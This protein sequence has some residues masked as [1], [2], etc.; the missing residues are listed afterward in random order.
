VILW[1]AAA[2]MAAGTVA[3]LV[4]PFVRPREDSGHNSELLVYQD[5]LAETDRDVERGLLT[6][7][8]A[9][10][11]RAEITRRMDK[12]PDTE[13]AGTGRTGTSGG[14]GID[15]IAISGVMVV[16][17]AGTLG[18]YLQLG[19]PGKRDLPFASRSVAPEGTNAASAAAQT[20]QG[21]EL[22]R[23]ANNL[24]QKMQERPD[25]LEGWMLLG[26][27]YMTLERWGDAA[28]AFGRAHTLSPRGPDI[29]ASY[30]EALYMAGGRRFDDQSK[31]V[32]QAALRANPR[33]AKS[34]FYW[35]LAQ[36]LSDQH[37]GALQT[38]VNLRVISPPNAP[39]LP[40]LSQR[41]QQSAEAGGINVAT[42]K[43]TL[44]PRQF[45]RP[46]PPVASAQPAP[47][48]R[49]ERGPT[50]EDVRAAQEMS[51]EDRMAFIRSMVEGLASRLEDNPND[52]AGWRRLAR[53]YRVLGETEKA[54]KAEAH[55]K[56]L[57]GAAN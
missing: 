24:A 49:P 21:S 36:A 11:L 52:L 37:K 26:R 56:K 48:T 6:E 22:N 43:P 46:V 1:V 30:A 17:L 19:S 35:G 25:N 31:S 32:L 16:I 5:Q 51:P 57:E 55:I 23:L 10:N 9:Q 12:L 3:A 29:A 54:E 39:W 44:T 42:L 50:Q 20:E 41:M 27:T 40:I 14:P 4:W 38:W 53:A 45:T 34:L 15:K 28:G 47:G 8:E 2:I 7:E 18:L 33:D 13:G